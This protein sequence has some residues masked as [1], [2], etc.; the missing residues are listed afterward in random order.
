MLFKPN[1]KS[2]DFMSSSLVGIAWILSKWLS[3]LSLKC[4]DLRI[5]QVLPVLSSL[6]LLSR[7]CECVLAIFSSHPRPCSIF[8]QSAE[9]QLQLWAL[10][11]AY[12][13]FLFQII[14]IY[15]V[16]PHGFDNIFTDPVANLLCHVASN[17]STF[18]TMSFHKSAPCESMRH[19][20]WCKS[21]DLCNTVNISSE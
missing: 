8:L 20:R 9:L 2:K 10:S 18:T 14:S 21:F 7:F 15:F 12:V 5:P 16:R 11:I 3:W 19:F 6:H 17:I 13:L 1:E 4:F